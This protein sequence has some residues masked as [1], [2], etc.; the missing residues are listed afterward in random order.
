MKIAITSQDGKGD[1]RFTGPPWDSFSS[2]LKRHG[3]EI[4][5]LDSKPDAI[6]FNNFSSSLLHKVGGSIPSSR[7][8]L[9]VWEPP[10]NLPQN[11]NRKNSKIFNNIFFPSTIWAK[12]YSGR[13]F[14]WPQGSHAES[15]KDSWEKRINKF[16]FIQANRWQ[17]VKN[18][19]YSL[20][21]R[22]LK[23]CNEYVDIYGRNWNQG[24][25]VDLLY[26][27]RSMPNALIAKSISL[28]AING[29][30]IRFNNCMGPVEDKLKTLRQYRFALIIEN[31]DEYVSEKIVDA[32]LAGVVPL[33][34][35]AELSRFGFPDGIANVCEPDERAIESTMKKLMADLIL[36]Q[37]IIESG[38]EFLNSDTFR[39]MLNYRVLSQLAEQI[40]VELK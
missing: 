5:H 29:V 40:C 15:P 36:Q 4:V 8:F 11:F 17:I 3:H 27:L 26:L 12:Q 2:T 10:V 32:L 31:S 13:A 18:E 9:I 14:S 38:K 20:R 25:M 16:C 24:L 1:F 30:G 28:R 6:I 39:A 21:R 34:V 37:T 22:V 7:K 33:Y 23:E 19:K 35:G